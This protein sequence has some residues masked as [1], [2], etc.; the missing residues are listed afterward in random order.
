MS[1]I[2][3]LWSAEDEATCIAYL[4]EAW[5]ETQW[6]PECEKA[7]Q[8]YIEEEEEEEEYEEEGE[9]EEEEE[10]QQQSGEFSRC[11]PSIVE[12]RITVGPPM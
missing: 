5:V 8:A 10:E 2:E 7:C 12:S 1:S 9:G 3:N 4:T 6:D 11:I